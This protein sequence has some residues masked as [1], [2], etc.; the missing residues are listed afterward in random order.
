MEAMQE[1][2]TVARV[3]NP[4][5]TLAGL[6]LN[7][8]I[9]EAF[10]TACLEQNYR[11]FSR[12]EDWLLSSLPDFPLSLTIPGSLPSRFSKVHLSLWGTA[13]LC[14]RQCG[15]SPAYSTNQTSF[16]K[17]IPAS[18]T[19]PVMCLSVF[20]SP[21]GIGSHVSQVGLKATKWLRATLIC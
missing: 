8:R 17:H 16:L 15:C 1:L 3:C 4:C 7:R 11:R 21:L 19:K 13:F 14:P 20:C 2:I 12:P 18:L 10:Q 5:V 9:L 6:G